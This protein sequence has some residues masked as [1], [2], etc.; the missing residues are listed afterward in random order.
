[1]MS[2]IDSSTLAAIFSGVCS[3]AG[4]LIANK[5]SNYRIE[6]LEKKLDK[7]ADKQDEMSKIQAV[8]SPCL[9]VNITSRC[10]QMR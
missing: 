7:Y 4:I 9:T 1:M 2:M 5:L 6:Q 3:L 10:I 8:Q